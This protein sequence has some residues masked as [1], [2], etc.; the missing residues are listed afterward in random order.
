M[1]GSCCRFALYPYVC[2]AADS[3]RRRASWYASPC[4]VPIEGSEQNRVHAEHGMNTITPGTPN[5]RECGYCLLC[6]L[7]SLELLPQQAITAP[8]VDMRKERPI[9][10]GKRHGSRC[11]DRS[12]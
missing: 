11:R 12:G 10:G 2:Q 8:R 7:S 4:C 9:F 1:R 6:A 5:P 3:F